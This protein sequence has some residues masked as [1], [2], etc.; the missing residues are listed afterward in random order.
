MTADQPAPRGTSLP[1]QWNWQ[2]HL[3][4]A[5]GAAGL[6]TVI[7]VVGRPVGWVSV[8]LVVVLAWGLF[9]VNV[10]IR[11]R[12]QMIRDGRLLWVRRL[13][14]WRSYDGRR[15]RRVDEVTTWSGICYRITDDTGLRALLPAA[16]FAGGH[17]TVLA[18]VLDLS[19]DAVFDKQAR[20]SVVHLH[21]RGLLDHHSARF[22]AEG[23]ALTAR[24]TTVA[25]PGHTGSRTLGTSNGQT[26][27]RAGG[28]ETGPSDVEPTSPRLRA[29]SRPHT[30]EQT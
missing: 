18:W 20:R 29:G 17:S 22:D 11:R 30:T 23:R 27:A 15:V 4:L 25:E 10:W 8:V 9:A 12:A 7:M 21:E 26:D 3:G 2:L 28:T 24:S 5:S 16:L 6:L 14:H 19:G 13:R 1:L